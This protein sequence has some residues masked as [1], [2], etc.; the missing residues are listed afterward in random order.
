MPNELQGWQ[1]TFLY[2]TQ[3]IKISNNGVSEE[4]QKCMKVLYA[5]FIGMMMAGIYCFFMLFFFP[6]VDPVTGLSFISLLFVIGC[7]IGWIDAG[8]KQRK[9]EEEEERQAEQD[10]TNELMREYLEKKLREDSKE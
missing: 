6:N 8:R 1:P 7:I 10:R 4:I 9:K 5:F 2:I 3:V